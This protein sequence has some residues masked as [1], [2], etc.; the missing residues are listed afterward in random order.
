METASRN[1]VSQ[2]VAKVHLHVC[3]DSVISRNKRVRP[4]GSSPRVWRQRG[5]TPGARF[6]RRFISTCVETAN[7][8]RRK[9]CR[10][11]VHLHV[12]GDSVLTVM[13][14]GSQLGS[15]PRVWRQPFMPDD[16]RT[17]E[18]FISTCVETASRSCSPTGPCQVHLHVCGD[19]ESRRRSTS[20]PLGSSPRVW[21]QHSVAESDSCH[22][23]F[24]STCVETA[25]FGVRGMTGTTV[26][27]HV[28]G[29]SDGHNF[30]PHCQN[31]SSPRVWRQLMRTVETIGCQ[32][33][34]STCVETAATEQSKFYHTKVHLHV[35]G[36]SGD[37]LRFYRLQRGSSPRV[38]RQ[39]VRSQN[40]G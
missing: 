6:D 5:D 11:S 19:S 25:V 26:H 18:R 39:P 21:R 3:G 13:R 40:R 9:K 29:D 20:R 24:I 2:T 1:Y 16:E 33:F 30:D 15:S 10:S 4:V 37:V 32:R 14:A 31:G 22:R 8:T 7:A 23:R 38:W 34:I 27:L 12:C 17:A 28:C 36:D 35:C